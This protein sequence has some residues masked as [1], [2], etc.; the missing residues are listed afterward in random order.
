MSDDGV[1][2]V[3]AAYQAAATLPRLLAALAAQA[4]QRPLEIVVVDDG[5][6]DDTAA[7]AER[8]GAR[9]L[10][11]ANAGPAAARN[12]GWRAARGNVVLFTDSD[13]VP[14]PDWTARLSAAVDGGYEV[15]GGTYGIANPGHWLAETIQAEIAWRHARFGREL[16]FAGSYNFA[17]TRRALEAVGGFDESYPAPSGEDNDL[18]YRLRDAGFRIRFARDAVVDHHHPVSL[19]RYLAEQARHG[20]WRVV[21]YRRHPRRLRGDGYAGPEELAAPPLAMSAL[22]LLA[23]APFRPAALGAAILAISLVLALHGVLA[24]RVARHARSATPLALA[25][26]GSLRTW[27]RG[28]GMLR[29]VARSLG[30]GRP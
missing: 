15:A 30:G 1:S 21:L 13:C 4:P 7:L 9:V 3:V 27:A 2:V 14:R 23:I 19:R 11:Q 25:A 18:S 16:D 26:V 24:F 10:R 28:L 22:M 5:S 12:R 20:E 29:G 17:A 6:A 8:A